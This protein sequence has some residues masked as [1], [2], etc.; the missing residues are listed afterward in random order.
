MEIRTKK[1]LTSI[2]IG[3]VGDMTIYSV[4]DFKKRFI[5]ETANFTD[6]AINLS[7]VGR[8]DTAGFQALLLARRAAEA[9]KKSL[10]FIDPSPDVLRLF[11]T[12]NEKIEDWSVYDRR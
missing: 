6:I 7:S 9:E 10:R 1:K 8:L 4:G 3:I 12:Y 2:E 5:E 11:S